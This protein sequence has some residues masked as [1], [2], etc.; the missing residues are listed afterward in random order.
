LQGASATGTPA[1]VNE[2]AP[3]NEASRSAPGRVAPDWAGEFIRPAAVRRN[4]NAPPD[5]ALRSFRVEQRG[6]SIRVLDADG[7]IY[8]GRLEAQAPADP[9]PDALTYGLAPS[10]TNVLQLEVSGTNLSSKKLLLFRGTI[11]T[12][13][14]SRIEGRALLDGRDR[15]VIDAAAR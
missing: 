15:I 1:L 6:T 7:S 12:G 2:V 5:Y 14:T 8:E 9:G 4:F 10:P 3:L 11:T 13:A